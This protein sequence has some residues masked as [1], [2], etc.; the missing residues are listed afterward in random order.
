MQRRLYR[1]ASCRSP[2]QGSEASSGELLAQ[3][4]TAAP[5]FVLLRTYE[6]M[7]PDKQACVLLANLPTVPGDL[8][9]GAIVVIERSQLRLRRLPLLRL[10]GRPAWTPP[11]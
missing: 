10:A 4:R 9:Q 6:P 1:S 11:T 8:E 3:Q 5:S 2:R 7:T